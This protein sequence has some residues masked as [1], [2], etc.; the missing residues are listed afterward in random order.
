MLFSLAAVNNSLPHP[1]PIPCIP[2]G[3]WYRPALFHV[4]PFFVSN[5]YQP[6][7]SFL[8]SCLTSCDSGRHVNFISGTVTTCSWISRL[9]MQGH[10]IW[11]HFP[12][13]LFVADINPFTAPACKTSGLKSAHIHASIQYIWWPCNK[14]ALN[15]V[16]FDRILMLR[17]RGGNA[18]MISNLAL[19]LVIFRI[20]ERQ[21][22]QWKG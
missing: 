20:T 5:S 1:I 8:W 9:H 21:A 16:N 14:S 18:R 15:T 17:R 13:L 4:H 7:V 11:I 10:C 2:A 6:A 3:V 12:V 19:L 22:R